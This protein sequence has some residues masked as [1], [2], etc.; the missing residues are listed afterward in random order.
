MGRYMDENLKGDNLY[1]QD[2][3]LSTD[4]GGETKGNRRLS[5]LSKG[6]TIYPR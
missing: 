2:Y 3:R 6:K 5:K 4:E 1:N